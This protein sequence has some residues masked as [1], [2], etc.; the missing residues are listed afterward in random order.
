MTLIFSVANSASNARGNFASRS[1]IKNRTRSR[2]SSVISRLRAC[3]SIQAALGL[4]VQAK[5]S[6]R[7]LPIE[8][9]TSTD[10]RRSQIV[11][12]V[13]KSQARIDSP[14]GS[15]EAAP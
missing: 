1:W 3:C 15:Q 14:F 2:S 9:N 4:L 8:R 5:Y 10:R 7:R 12:T 11:S 13:K 6:T